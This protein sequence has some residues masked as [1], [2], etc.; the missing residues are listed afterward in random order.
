MKKQ[1]NVNN[2]L[3]GLGMHEIFAESYARVFNI[4]KELALEIVKSRVND[5]LNRTAKNIQNNN[6]NIKEGE[7]NQKLSE[8]SIDDILNNDNIIKDK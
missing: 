1:K 4:D 3:K 5:I 7:I 8:M 2:I 6:F